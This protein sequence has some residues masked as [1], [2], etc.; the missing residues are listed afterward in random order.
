M[1]CSEVEYGSEHNWA[2]LVSCG[3]GTVQEFGLCSNLE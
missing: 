2:C 1:W 3:T